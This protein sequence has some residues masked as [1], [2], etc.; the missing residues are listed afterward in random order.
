MYILLFF[1]GLLDCYLLFL[2]FFFVHVRVCS[3][4]LFPCSHSSLLSVTPSAAKVI[5]T[6]VGRCSISLSSSFLLRFFVITFVLPSFLAALEL[7]GF[8]SV[9]F[10]V[11]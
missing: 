11:I 2:S 3:S 9:P 6:S 1:Q 5:V 4:V 7:S 10:S 8:D